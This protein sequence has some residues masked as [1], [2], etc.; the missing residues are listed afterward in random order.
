MKKY[1]LLELQVQYVEED[2]ITGSIEGDENDYGIGELPF[3][4]GVN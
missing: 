4:V 1:E 2:V 3:E